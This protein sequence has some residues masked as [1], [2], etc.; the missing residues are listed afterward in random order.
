MV[1]TRMKIGCVAFVL[2][3]ATAI[4]KNW[5]PGISETMVAIASTTVLGYILGDTFR[6]SDK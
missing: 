1:K 2:I 3:L 6:K 4:A 5:L